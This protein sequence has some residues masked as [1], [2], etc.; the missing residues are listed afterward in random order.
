M[1]P[2][3]AGTDIRLVLLDLDGTLYVGS[4]AVHGA[5]AAVERLRGMGLHVRFT[6]NTDSM[7]PA[8]VVSRL[9]GMG[10]DCAP[11]EIVTPVA[12]AHRLFTGPPPAR[13][14]AIAAPAVRDALAP[15]V[16]G[17][18]GNPTHV[19][20]A[21]PSYGATYADLDAAFLALRRGAVL[22]ATQMGRWCRRDDGEHLDTGGWVRLLEYA[23]EAQAL[24]LGKP[25]PD[26]FRL[27]LEAAGIEARQAVVVGDDRAADVGGGRAAGC[28]TV[29][30]RT[31]K[32]GGGS[33][34]EPDVLVDSVAD[35]PDLLAGD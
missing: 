19:L 18:D 15:H 35:L 31:G 12:L 23:A 21:D 22:V 34:P 7:P 3:L 8:A 28:H 25:S 33:G 26:F 2:A 14:L 29:L 4:R 20:I 11:D 10:V 13:V 1:K 30:V 17:A 27:A 6:T 32:A 24:V 5:A 16:V 9:A